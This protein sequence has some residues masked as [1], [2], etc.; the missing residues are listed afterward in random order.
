[1]ELLARVPSLRTDVPLGDLAVSGCTHDS[2]AVITGDLYAALPGQT[3]HGADFAE[4]AVARGAV[5]VLTDQER[6]VGVSSLGIPVLVADSP[7][8]VLG[9]V[10]AWV[11]GDP[12][13][14]MLMLGVTGTNG[15]TTTGFLL[16]AGLRSAGMRTGLIGTVVTRIGDDVAPS[17]RTTP[18]ATDLQAL[19]AVMRERRVE[20]V[21]MEV[22]SHALSLGRVEAITYDL[23]GFTNLT[24][25]HLDFHGTMEAYFQAKAS[26]FTPAHARRGVAIVD[27]PPGRRLAAEAPIPVASLATT[28]KADWWVDDVECTGGGS[29]FT[30]HGLGLSLPCRTPLPGRFNVDNL[31]LAVCMLVEAGIAPELAVAGVAGLAG[32]P[33]RME[34]VDA[35]QPFAALVDYAHT[36]EAVTTLLRSLRGVTAG[37]LLLVLGCGG[38]RDTAK[39]ALMGRAAVAGADVVVLTNDN[40]RGEDPMVILAAMAEQ[41]PGAV[42]EPDRRAAI[43]LAVAQARPGDVLVVAGKGHESGQ[44]VAGVI[45]P[46]DDR[47]ELRRALS[48]V[49][50]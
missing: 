39:R 32:V 22:S 40:P 47:Q 18:E 5:A 17:V 35:G 9:Q 1:M 31:A 21:A 38:D 44:E 2:R 3:V 28:G 4:Q 16:E 11:H 45:T 6:C 25:D 34:R 10:A 46:F 27:E 15:K 7:R 42:I 14:H 33:G 23:A 13:E 48:A 41:A 30:L 29:S 26:L 24:Q 49:T 19:L 50:S 12:A 8:A 20:A 43:A 36:P 37:R